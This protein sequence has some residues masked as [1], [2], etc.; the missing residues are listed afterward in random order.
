MKLFKLQHFF[1]FFL[2]AELSN[3][4]G[5]SY[6]TYIVISGCRGETILAFCRACQETLLL[7]CR[8]IVFYDHLARLAH[9]LISGFAFCCVWLEWRCCL[10]RRLLNRTNF[11]GKQPGHKTCECKGIE[12]V[13]KQS[14]HPLQGLT[15]CKINIKDINNPVLHS[16]PI[17]LWTA[18]RD[19][20]KIW[21]Y[22]T[23]S[24]DP[25]ITVWVC[26]RASG[27]PHKQSRSLQEHQKTSLDR[28]ESST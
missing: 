14:C 10:A 20:R 17:L 1:W 15:A 6:S 4:L 7:C 27:D 2:S 23:A 13:D 21:T 5:L 12:E 24:G 22:P 19:R 9:S 28:L 8:A 16:L 11:P 25:Q 26:R 18:W 3:I